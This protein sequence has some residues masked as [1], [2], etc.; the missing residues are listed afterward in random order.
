MARILLG[1]KNNILTATLNTTAKTLVIANCTAFDLTQS[2]LEYVYDVTTSQEFDLK[3]VVSCVRT[4]SGGLPIFTYTF[5][6]LPVGAI[7][8]GD[9]LYVYLQ[10]PTQF[11]DFLQLQ[12]I[13]TA[14]I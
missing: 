14:T 9:T 7:A 2:D 4:W 13:A 3:Q 5:A 11:M 10:V 6:R 1:N 8:N 12:V